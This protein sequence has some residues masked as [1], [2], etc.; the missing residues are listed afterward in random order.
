[1]WRPAAVLAFLS[2]L[3]LTS[4]TNDPLKETLKQDSTIDTD[5]VSSDP[6]PRVHNVASLGK[7][8]REKMPQEAKELEVASLGDVPPHA[9]STTESRTETTVVKASEEHTALT[10]DAEE[11]AKIEAGPDFAAKVQ[12]ELVRLGCYKGAVDNIWGPLSR[13]AVAKFNRMASESLPIDRPTPKLLAKLRKLSGNFCVTG[14][15]SPKGGK[16]CR[17]ASRQPGEAKKPLPSYLPPWMRGQDTPAQETIATAST[18]PSPQ[19]MV[20]VWTERKTAREVDDYRRHEPWREH[21]RSRRRWSPPTDF[22][23][24]R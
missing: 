20:E 7:T 4:R 15:L 17:V 21:R 1:M 23:P 8:D 22:W 11:I 19:Q 12:T 18:E 16:E 6:A 5:K 9:P 24:G 14:C 3:I 2:L 13:G 10:V